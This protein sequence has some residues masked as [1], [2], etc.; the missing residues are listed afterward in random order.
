MTNQVKGAIYENYIEY[1]FRFLLDIESRSDDEPIL[2]SRNVSFV[3][4]GS[5][6]QFDIYYD[7][8]KA[9]V[10]HRVAIECKNHGRPVELSMA[11]EFYAKLSE[12]HNITGVFVSNSGYQSG[13]KSWLE[14]KEIMALSTSDLPNFF[15]LI[16]IRSSN[17]GICNT[18]SFRKMNESA[19]VLS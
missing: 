11:R 3:K 5:P 10:L 19:F 4:N 18:A 2:I 13:A 12:F 17:R 6:N 16:G 1:V 8:S 7:F 9:G 14:D 15:N